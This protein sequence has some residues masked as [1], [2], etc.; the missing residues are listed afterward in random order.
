MRLQR[1]HQPVQEA[2]VL[3]DRV[4]AHRRACWPAPTRAGTPACAPRPRPSDTPSSSTRRHRPDFPCWL[5]FQSSIASSAA[6]GWAIASSGPSARTSRSASVTTVAISRIESGWCRARSSPGRSRSTASRCPSSPCTRRRRSKFERMIAQRPCWRRPSSWPPPRCCCPPTRAWRGSTG[7]F[8]AALAGRK[9]PLRRSPA[10][11]IRA[12]PG[13]PTTSTRWLC[14]PRIGEQVE[15]AAGRAGLAPGSDGHAARTPAAL[16]S[17]G[18]GVVGAEH[19]A[20]DPRMHHRH[21]AHRAGLEGDV[22]RGAGQP[23]VAQRPAR[24]A[25]GDD[26]GVRA[27]VVL[28]DVAVPALAEQ[29]ALGRHQHRPDRDLVVLALG[30]VGERQGVA[31][32]VIVVV[33]IGSTR[34]SPSQLKRDRCGPCS[35]VIRTPDR[36]ARP[37]MGRSGGA[38]GQ[39]LASRAAY[40]HSIVA[41]GLP[42]MS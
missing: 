3:A 30:A 37:S 15:H 42:L 35:N 32:P 25:H 39:W 38:A 7:P 17:A 11:S 36:H 18:L 8:P 6:T 20:R 26:L 31:H 28:G 9:Y 41:G 29:F 1:R 19:H 14:S 12:Q 34:Q 40:S 22:Q 33:L 4:A 5:R 21:R 10:S 2:A 23:V 24:L 27:G 13:G 16:P